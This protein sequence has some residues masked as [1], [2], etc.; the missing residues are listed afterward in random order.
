MRW[1]VLGLVL[2]FTCLTGIAGEEEESRPMAFVHPIFQE[3]YN[4]VMAEAAPY[5]AAWIEELQKPNDKGYSGIR[6]HA[7]PTEEKELANHIWRRWLIFP[8]RIAAPRTST[9]H[10]KAVDAWVSK[11]LESLH[12]EQRFKNLTPEEKDHLLWELDEFFFVEFNW[13]LSVLN[14]QVDSFH[15]CRA[16]PS[17]YQLNELYGAYLNVWLTAAIWYEAR[18]KFIPA[19]VGLGIL[20]QDGYYHKFRGLIE[21]VHDCRVAVIRASDPKYSW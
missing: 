18:M 15:T 20:T 21:N 12:I 17:E 6:Y 10:V 16:A 19:M 7:I 3:W 4:G 8:Y 1:V 2:S 5:R 14:G 11:I 13:L 9:A